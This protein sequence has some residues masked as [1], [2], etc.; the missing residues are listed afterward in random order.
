MKQLLQEMKSGETHVVEVPVPQPGAKTALVKT[1]ASLIS[2]G[3]ERMLVE[4]AQQSMLG[5]AK[6]RPDLVR[7]VV[8]KAKREGIAN[9]LDAA[10]NRLDQPMAL[11]YS[12]AG[13]I[14][15]VGPELEGFK[16]GDRVACGGGGY[17]VHAEYAVVPQNLLVKVPDEV[18]LEHASFA[19]LGAIAMQ[20]FRLA[21]PQVGERIA[22]IGLGLLGLLTVGIAQAAGCMVLGIDLDSQRVNLARQLGAQAVLR[23]NAE[24]A[25]EAF[26]KGRGVDAVIICADTKSNDPVNLAGEIARSK[27]KVIAVGAVGLSI[28]RKT[29]YQKE[30]EL[31]VSRS[32]GPGRYDTNY[33]EKGIDY[34]IDYVRWSEQRNMESFIELL[35]SKKLDLEPLISHRFSIEE[36]S[37]A[38]GMITAKSKE[39][40][41]GVVLTYTGTAVE[42]LTSVT[43]LNAPIVRLR[44]GEVIALGVLGAGNFALSTFLPVVKKVGGVAPVGIVSGSG[45]S[46]RHAAQ[47]FGFGF[48]GSDP[49][50]IFSDT[51]INVVAILTRHHLHSEQVLRALET[52]KH[53][54]CEKPLVINRSQLDSVM[55]VVGKTESSLLMV[56]YNR[57]F[58][59]LAQKMKTFLDGRSEPMVI[60][61][62]A[63][64]GF[65]P[66]DH[67]TQDT[68]V[69]GGRIIGEACH[70]IDFLTFMVGQNPM[71]VSAVALPD[72]GK[73]NQDNVVISL[74]YPDGSLG[75][76]TYVAN[77]DKAFA[78]ER[79]EVFCG[80]RVAV[81]DD[82][83]KLEM[84]Q[85]GRVKRVKSALHQDKGHQAAWTAF[86]DSIRTH[87][88][89]PI[90]YDQLFATSSA[91]LVA[92]KAL[93]E[94]GTLSIVP[95]GV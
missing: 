14:V 76:I 4:F 63:N 33:E 45:L 86:I 35:A 58:A 6:S 73:Y 15:E 62:R 42:K 12:S 51:A 88:T 1:V 7:Q 70:F 56:G 50:I 92:L 64:A 21:Q 36:A 74:T 91:S 23:R 83:R 43:N 75:T 59:P 48:A 79:I 40:F 16:P 95:P 29:Y 8:D 67:W 17:A 37:Q 81:L 65:L 61:Y 57:R 78:K 52:K 53:I 41:L 9:T 2:V 72:N 24:E 38:Y 27:A 34:P 87:G 71:S 5:K 46:A 10:L 31:V 3:T 84:T 44:P 93:Q 77:G 49:E 11:G 28:P 60:Q 22:I 13:T 54:Y 90:P 32:Y 20:G 18:S 94:G 66:L 30:L 69:G 25:A 82:F 80:G 19:T 89:P 26:S 85:K 39:P 55:S 68:A 47:K